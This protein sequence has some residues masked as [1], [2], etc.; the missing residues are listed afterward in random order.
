MAFSFVTGE[1]V[2]PLI[3]GSVTGWR[4]DLLTKTLENMSARL[5]A[6]YPGL[7]AAFSEADDDS[8]LVGL[9]K[10]MI[11]E[12]ARKVVTNPDGMSSE[13]A[14]PYAYSRFDSEDYAKSMFNRQD[15][16]SLELLLNSE[17]SRKARRA[18]MHLE[19]LPAA[20]MPRRGRY[21]NSDPWRRR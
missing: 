2:K 10:T 9:V 14:G 21:T 18:T 13:T 4:E 19:T 12:V 16:A 1:E 11:S 15:L 5:S 8:D 6:W 17:K 20:P 3:K 7:R